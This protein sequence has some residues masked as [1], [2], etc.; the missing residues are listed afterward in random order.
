MRVGL[1]IAPLVQ[2]GAGTA[3]VV[4]GLQRAL[5][6]RPRLEIVPLSFGSL[7][8]A[9]T[10][11]RDVAWYPGGIAWQARDLDVLH[12]TTMRGP[13]HA[14]PPVVVTVHDV[15][16]L[17][18]PEAFPVWHRHTGRL[19]LRL[20]VRSADAI[21]AVSAFTRDA[22]ADTTALTSLA[23]P[24]PTLPDQ[25]GDYAIAIPGATVTL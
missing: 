6:G 17:R 21:V 24:A 4:R 14:R 18:V 7:G 1:D 23:D 8:R 19:A 2:T 5:E 20:A 12:C 25:H 15:A 11:A 9:A 3:R 13:L 10:V 22:L 16:L